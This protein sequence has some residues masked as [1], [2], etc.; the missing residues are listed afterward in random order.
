MA[1]ALGPL[2]RVAAHFGKRGDTFHH[3]AIG[4]RKRIFHRHIALIGC[5][6]RQSPIGVV[7]IQV[8]GDAQVVD[9]R[10][11]VAGIEIALP[12]H[13]RKPPEVLIFV[14][15]TVAPAEGLKGDEVFTFLY[16][17]SD[18]KLGRHLGVFG[19]ACKASV[20][21][22][23]DV[24]SDAP[25]VGNHLFAARPVVGHD[26]GTAVG[27]HVIVAH[28]HLGRHSVEVSAPCEAD[29]HI[30][31]VAI[32][33][34]FPVARHRHHGPR[35]VI[36][37][38]QIEVGGPLVGVLHPLEFPQTVEAQE[39]FRLLFVV[40]RKVLLGAVESEKLGVEWQS[41]DLVDLKIVP[42]GPCRGRSGSAGLGSRHGGRCQERKEQ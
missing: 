33:V 10:L 38:R 35:R 41:V 34:E 18:V 8:G 26:D 14:P 17:G 16:I 4:I 21:V 39:V 5:F 22:E 28:R 2:E 32:A 36:K 12:G 19:I 9:V 37:R 27:P 1:L 42:F 11:A 3:L 15:R 25:E 23:V 6:D 40:N 13:T 24:G 7:G 29:V 20:D 31:R 30:E